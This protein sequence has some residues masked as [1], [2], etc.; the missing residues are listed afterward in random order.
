MESGGH[1]FESMRRKYG[2]GGCET[3]Q[4]WTR[5]YGNGTRGKVIRVEKPEEKNELRRLRERVHKLEA[6]LADAHVDLAVE[7]AYM[8]MACERAGIRDLEAFKKKADGKPDA[9]P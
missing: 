2:I 1:T 7:R 6:A 3:I 4:G 8:R 5:K 9:A